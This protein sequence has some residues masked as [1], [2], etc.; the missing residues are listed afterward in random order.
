M[1]APV[2]SDVYELRP[3]YRVRRPDGTSRTVLPRQGG[4]GWAVFDGSSTDRLR[5][6]QHW[7]RTVAS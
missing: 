5:Q 2:M 1:S 7:A 4:D 6:P 3:G